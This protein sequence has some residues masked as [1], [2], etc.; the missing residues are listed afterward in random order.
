M[1]R[2]RIRLSL[3]RASTDL[4]GKGS[5][6]PENYAGGGSLESCLQEGTEHRGNGSSGGKMRPGKLVVA[7]G[8]IAALVLLGAILYA[9][10]FI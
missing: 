2:H 9:R 8:I 4:R 5:V 6:E 7:I 3:V 10:I 1:S